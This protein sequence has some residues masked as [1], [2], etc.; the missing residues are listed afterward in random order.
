[1]R[2]GGAAPAVLRP[3][4]LRCTQRSTA[5]AARAASGLGLLALLGWAGFPAPFLSLSFF[6]PLFAFFRPSAPRAHPPGAA[7]GPGQGGARGVDRTLTALR[8]PLAPGLVNGA[9][10]RCPCKCPLHF[11]FPGCFGLGLQAL[12]RRR[13]KRSC[14]GKGRGEVFA[15]AAQAALEW[16]GAGRGGADSAR[17]PAISKTHA[18]PRRRG[19][20]AT[21]HAR[22]GAAPHSQGAAD[23]LLQRPQDPRRAHAPAAEGG[24]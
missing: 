15:A 13:R 8:A 21:L 20:P 22:A 19:S 4:C 6:P 23:R 18:S 9:E 11:S 3:G 7:A 24:R 14:K 16:C 5:H 12:G 1:M 17:G 10:P 2:R